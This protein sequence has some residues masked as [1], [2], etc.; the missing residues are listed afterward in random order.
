MKGKN[1]GAIMTQHQYEIEERDRAQIKE[2]FLTGQI[3]AE[4]AVFIMHLLGFS[5]TRAK[6]QNGL[7]A[8]PILRG[9]MK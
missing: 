2:Y 1:K 8:S 7:P 5:A 4:V 3:S 6:R 9:L